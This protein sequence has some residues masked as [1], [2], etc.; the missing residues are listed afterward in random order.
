MY[1]GVFL[2]CNIWLLLML[3][4]SISMGYSVG[5]A[6]L[7]SRQS[8]IV[9]LFFAECFALQAAFLSPTGFMTP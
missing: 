2:R 8:D 1:L 4:I 6:W 9:A 7:D 3:R 5:L